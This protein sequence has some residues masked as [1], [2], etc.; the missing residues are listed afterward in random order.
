MPERK[1]L[2]RDAAA[3]GPMLSAWRRDLHRR[4]ELG[5]SCPRAAALVAGELRGLGL[6]VR[7]GL[8]HSGVLGILRGGSGPTAA[9]RVD[10]D[11]LP[12]EEQTG[13]DFASEIPDR[14]HACGHDGHTALGLGAARLL[15]ARRDAL[16]GTLLFLFQPGEEYPGGA[17]L[18]IADGALDDPNPDVILGC[19]LFPALERGRVGVCSGPA[20]AG[21]EEFTLTVTGRGGHAARPHECANPIQAA[22]RLV[23]DLQGIAAGRVDAREPLVLTVAEFQAGS[24]HNVIPEHAVLRGTLRFL[25]ETAREAAM[26][27]VRRLVRGVEAAWGVH[28]TLESRVDGPPMRLPEDLAGLVRGWCADLLS[29]E[30]VELLTRPS[31]GAEDFAYFAEARPAAYLRLGCRDAA[32]SAGLH[33][34]FFD[35]DEALLPDACATLAWCLWRFLTDWPRISTFS[36][37]C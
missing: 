33:T 9:L 6:E 13:L 1:A 30:R 10:M 26:H 22:S 35:F 25:S 31:M 16:P 24:G 34:P 12:L 37:V 36:P 23:L 17:R 20:T 3:L 28:V 32:R 21:N 19:H 15:A 2:L 5:L 4:P 14:M 18:M 29:S 27:E 8:A 7:E 11:A